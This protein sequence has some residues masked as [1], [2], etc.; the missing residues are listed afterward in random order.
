[1]TDIDY[2]DEDFLPSEEE[3]DEI[4]D[5]LIA[6]SELDTPFGQAVKTELNSL[7][8]PNQLPFFIAP[9]WRHGTEKPRFPEKLLSITAVLWIKGR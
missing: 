4:W 5:F 9:C 8:P 1:M 3:L 2:H 7:P 6:Q